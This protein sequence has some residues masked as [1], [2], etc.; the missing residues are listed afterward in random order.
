MVSHGRG[1]K[2][3]FPRSRRCV[4]DACSGLKAGAQVLEMAGE[5]QPLADLREFKRR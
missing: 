3:G 5:G 4:D 2:R 1:H